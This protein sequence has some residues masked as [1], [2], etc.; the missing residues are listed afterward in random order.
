MS[1]NVSQP[2]QEHARAIQRLTDHL[3]VDYADRFDVDLEDHV[4]ELKQTFDRFCGSLSEPG[5]PGAY[6]RWHL[7]EPMLEHN[8]VTAMCSSLLIFAH[9]VSILQVRG[10]VD[11]LEEP[12]KRLWRE[13]DNR[14][15]AFFSEA[16]PYQEP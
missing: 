14:Y 12:L 8:Y 4:R 13:L 1:Q 16:P 6:P 7:S 5:Q 3:L 10:S 2:A 11:S 15:R 9:E